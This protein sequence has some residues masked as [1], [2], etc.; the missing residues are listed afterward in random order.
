MGVGGVRQCNCVCGVRHC[1]CVSGVRHCNCVRGVGR[2]THGQSWGR[3]QSLGFVHTTGDNT[4]EKPATQHGQK[5]ST[6]AP[7]YWPANSEQC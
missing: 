1:N 2:Y 5:L 7:V 6:V 4:Q 3:Q